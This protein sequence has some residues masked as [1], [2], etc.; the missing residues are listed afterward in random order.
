[1]I[2]DTIEYRG[3]IGVLYQFLGTDVGSV[4]AVIRIENRYLFVSIE[5]IE[6]TDKPLEP[7]RPPK[8]KKTK[9]KAKKVLT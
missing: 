9:K 5:D 7:I 2:G 8:K 4:R 1:M 6:K 3:K